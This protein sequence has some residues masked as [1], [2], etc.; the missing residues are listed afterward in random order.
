VPRVE[1]LVPTRTTSDCGSSPPA[2]EACDAERI[3]L[4]LGEHG[5]WTYD[6]H[7]RST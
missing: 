3:R 5:M 4:R 6:P 1:S 7:D 2:T